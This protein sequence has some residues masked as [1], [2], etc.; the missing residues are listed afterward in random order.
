PL[1]EAYMVRITDKSDNVVYEKAINAGN[2]VG[3][4]IDISAYPEGRY[5]V[6]IENNGESFTG[7][8]DTK[9][10]GIQELKSSRIEELKS[11]YNL[12]GQRVTTPVK[13]GIYIQNGKKLIIK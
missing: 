11:I 10:T 13:G 5:T 1:D 7:E 4:N 6:T 2:I 12:Q 8:F 3:L 9:T